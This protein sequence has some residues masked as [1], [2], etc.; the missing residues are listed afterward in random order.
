[1]CKSSNAHLAFAIM[2]L[3]VFLNAC[4]ETAQSEMTREAGSQEQMQDTFTEPTTQM[5]LPPASSGE[6]VMNVSETQ[7]V[8][9]EDSS[10]AAGD[11]ETNGGDQPTTPSNSGSDDT[12]VDN[13]A[14]PNESDDDPCMGLDYLGRCNGD[15]SEW[16]SPNNEYQRVDCASRGQRCGWIDEQTGWYCGGTPDAAGDGDTLDGT[17]EGSGDPVS[18]DE[19]CGNGMEIE[20]SAFANEARTTE[21]LNT[22]ECDELMTITARVHSQDMCDQGYFSHTSL[23]G[24]TPWDR[25]REQGVSFG[26]GAENIAQGQRN[27]LSVHD[28]WMNSPGHRANILGGGLRRVGVGFVNCNGRH[29]W[30]QVFAD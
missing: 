10:P 29:F 17:A 1:M 21:G 3:A 26:R 30:T 20:V 27:A 19:A 9:E 25:M 14:N 12:S 11:V 18:L 6:P 2:N 16:C 15:V 23:D 5:A 7:A 22:L 4:G 28:A 8:D 24:R 13:D